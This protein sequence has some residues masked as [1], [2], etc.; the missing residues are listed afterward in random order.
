MFD[1][2]VICCQ[3]LHSA[4]NCGPPHVTD[5]HRSLSDVKQAYS[6]SARMQRETKILDKLKKHV[7]PLE[8]SATQFTTRFS[9]SLRKVTNMA[10]GIATLSCV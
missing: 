6:I 2:R 5:M 1:F 3:C 8:G 7:A 10:D 4:C 9:E